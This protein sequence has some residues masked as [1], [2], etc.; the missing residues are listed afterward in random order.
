MDIRIL[1]EVWPDPAI[2]STIAITKLPLGRNIPTKK[3]NKK[4]KCDF[5]KFFSS[6]N[7]LA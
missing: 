6:S 1:E 5:F 2:R 7:F 4:E 3:M